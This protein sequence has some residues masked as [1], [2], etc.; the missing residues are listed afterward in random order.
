MGLSGAH[1]DKYYKQRIIK[2]LKAIIFIGVAV[3]AIAAN[4][5]AMKRNI[6]WDE[7]DFRNARVIAERTQTP[8]PPKTLPASATRKKVLTEWGNEEAQFACLKVLNRIRD[9]ERR[10]LDHSRMLAKK[11]M[12]TIEKR[13]KAHKERNTLEWDY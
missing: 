13:K 12:D 6:G 4:C 10:K 1:N 8:P 9:E 5:N 2:M 11:I 7:E 3:L